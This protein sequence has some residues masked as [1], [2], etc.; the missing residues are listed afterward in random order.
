MEAKNTK[1]NAL[2]ANIKARAKYAKEKTTRIAVDL[3]HSTDGDII[4]FMETKSP[5]QAYIKELIREKMAEK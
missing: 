1:K 2:S 4:E 5:K 3:Y